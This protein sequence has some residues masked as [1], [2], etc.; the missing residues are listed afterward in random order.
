MTIGMIQGG[1]RGA[2]GKATGFT[3][4]ELLVVIAVLAILITML[5]PT[6]SHA[7]IAARRIKVDALFYTLTTSLE[8]FREEA[9]F[10]DDYPPSHWHTDGDHGDAGGDPLDNPGDYTAQGGETL[11]W[12]LSGADYL[13]TPGFNGPLHTNDPDGLYRIENDKPAVSRSTFLYH[14]KAEVSDEDYEIDGRKARVY[15]DSFGRP[16]LY[17]RA[18]PSATSIVG[19]YDYNDNEK[20]VDG[21]PLADESSDPDYQRFSYLIEDTGVT[22]V[23]RPHNADS[24]ILLSAGPDKQYGTKDDMTNYPLSAKNLENLPE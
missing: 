16:V 14:D 13:G 19:I 15:L 18:N 3:L 10:G 20:I 5:V 9:R 11:L 17:Y 23:E 22:V 2:A 21:H 24:F 4:I 12:A 7:R 8:M 6:L 1:R